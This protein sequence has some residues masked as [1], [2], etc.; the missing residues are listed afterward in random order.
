[1][2]LD[3]LAQR[4]YWKIMAKP[5]V[6]MTPQQ[7]SALVL[8]DASPADLTPLAQLH[9]DT[10]NETHVGP[11]GSGPTFAVREWQWRQH[12]AE[13]HAANFVLVI[14]APSGEFVGFAWYHAALGEAFG[15]RLNKIYVRRSHQRQG[16][17]HV[18]VRAGVDRLLA[19][20]ITSM[21]L[22]T[23]VDNV[24]ACSFYE[25]LGAQRQ[26]GDDGRFHGKYGW[27]DLH[28]LRDKLNP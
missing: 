27:P 16:L 23:E 7:L 8:R 21:F 19:N 9:V 26:L 18:L 14:E 20:G 6:P 12:L 5:H 1:M 25:G 11:F 10:F 3:R 15:A 17:G 22:F 2:W 4:I 24:P 13:L 28:A